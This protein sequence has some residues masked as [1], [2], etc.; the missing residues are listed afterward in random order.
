ML[1]ALMQKHA[2]LCDQQQAIV[3]KAITEGRGMTEDENTQFNALQTEI[4]GLAATI[5]AAQAVQDR[6]ASLDEPAGKIIRPTG[7][8]GDVQK[9]KLDDGGFQN[10]GEFLHAIKFGDNKGRLQ[11]LSTSDVGIMIPPAF[12]QQIM[13]LN[14]EAEIVMPRAF[15]IPA[16]DPPDAPFIIPYFQQGAD[17]ALGGISLTW[18][19]EAKTVS[20]TS[21][22][23]IKD[24]TLQP[25]EVS[26]MATINNKTLTNWGA[27]G[28]F[29]ENLLRQAWVSGRD[30]KFLRGSGVGCPLGALNA[31]GAIK[32]KRNTSSDIKYVDV[33]TMLSRFYPDALS[34]AIFIASITALP[35]LMQLADSQG[36]LILV[37]G[38]ATK[39]IPTTLAGVPLKFV[40][41]LP[42]IGN[43]GDL[44]LVNFNYY[45]IKP[46]SGPFVAISEHV[47]F[48]TNQ[49]VFKIVAN[50]D[51]QPWVKD[52][53]KLE[54][55][56]TTV[57][58]YVILE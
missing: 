19:A 33:V 6:A 57:S 56:S 37:L 10:V 26:G 17:G 13:Q 23:K 9:D 27:A 4:D 5:Q 34:G 14:P 16:G 41:K 3:N 2:D 45:L 25:Q 29:I 32:I 39:G 30:Y 20:D 55:G 43:E 47:K 22:P 7:E 52:P 31:P 44:F 50:I 1:R 35:A 51:G 18:T 28:G 12:S 53:L 49:T 24:M 58:P 54:D 21:D 48:T 15:V 38:D 42:T 46:G 11:N 40:G 36:R 8:I